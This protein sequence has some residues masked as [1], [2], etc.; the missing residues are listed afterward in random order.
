M[1]VVFPWR[2]LMAGRE[3]AGVQIVKQ[4][5]EICHPDVKL[6]VII[7][8]GELHK[9]DLIRRASE[10]AIEEGADFVKTST[11]K[12]AVNAT[13]EAAEIML[14]VIKSSQQDVGLM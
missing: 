11:G 6:K 12:V 1:D 9:P 8:S 4:C 10:I 13:L 7:E 5:R 3:M 14:D 2:K